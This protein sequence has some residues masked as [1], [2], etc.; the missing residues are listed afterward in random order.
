MI[1]RTAKVFEEVN[2][3]CPAR[4]MMVQLSTPTLTLRA[5]MQALQPDS[6]TD[7]QTHRETTKSCQLPIT[8]CAA[9]RSAEN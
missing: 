4:N 6:Q 8:L 3:K 1:H 9:V 7:R 2:K 5:T